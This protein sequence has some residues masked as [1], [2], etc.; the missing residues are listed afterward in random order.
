MLTVIYENASNDNER[1]MALDRLLKS[2]E[3]TTRDWRS[4]TIKDFQGY[5]LPIL[6]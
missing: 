5:S 1:N 6:L 3:S 4:V 2:F